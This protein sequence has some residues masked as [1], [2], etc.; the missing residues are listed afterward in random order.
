MKS[1]Y[2][3]GNKPDWDKIYTRIRRSV[4]GEV[5]EADVDDVVQEAVIAI[6]HKLESYDS[7]G[8]KF[9]TWFLTITRNKIADW[10]RRQASMKRKLLAFENHLA[11][12]G[13]PMTPNEKPSV[14]L[15]L[16]LSCLEKVPPKHK[17]ILWIMLKHS[18]ISPRDLLKITD[19]QNIY[20]MKSQVARAL[21]SIR[22]HSRFALVLPK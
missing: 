5:P 16:F 14:N 10:H 22:R 13:Q 3:L 12:N 4:I 1:D 6:S 8:A 9:S 2:Y 20:T 18:T 19:G 7:G 17:A 21:K 15:R 11:I